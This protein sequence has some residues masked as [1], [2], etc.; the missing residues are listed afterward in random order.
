M[1]QHLGSS[2]GERLAI[3]PLSEAVVRIDDHHPVLLIRDTAPLVGDGDDVV[4][5]LA[6]VNRDDYLTPLAFQSMLTK[7][8][9]RSLLG[10]GGCLQVGVI[11]LGEDID[12]ELKVRPINGVLD[13]TVVL[14][15]SADGSG[16]G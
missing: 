6:A 9:I 13:D 8:G 5:L 10:S 7:D 4:E 2:Q 3:V 1:L 16:P 15:I 11:V 14:I 12:A